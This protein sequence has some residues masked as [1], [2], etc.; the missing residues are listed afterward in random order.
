MEDEVWVED[1][2]R[3]RMQGFDPDTAQSMAG[4]RG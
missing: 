1:P 2:V 4:W 3:K